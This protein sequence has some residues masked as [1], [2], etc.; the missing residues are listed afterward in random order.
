[1]LVKAACLETLGV[2][3]SCVPHELLEDFIV[4]LRLNHE[5]G[6]GDNFAKVLDELPSLRRQLLEV[7]RRVFDNIGKGFV[8]LLVGGHTA[9]S[10][11]LNDAIEPELSKG[12]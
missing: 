1:M 4:I 10:E 11:S 8:D 12:N 7:D 5:A 6:C 9:L 3:E 2:D